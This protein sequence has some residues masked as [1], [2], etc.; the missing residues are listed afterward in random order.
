MPHQCVYRH[1]PSCYQTLCGPCSE[2]LTW[3]AEV[4]KSTNVLKQRVAVGFI[5]QTET[6]TAREAE[7]TN[8]LVFLADLDERHS[9]EIY[10]FA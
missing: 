7:E 2:P 3:I 5:G 6:V 9:V 1:Q 4:W 10:N 8:V